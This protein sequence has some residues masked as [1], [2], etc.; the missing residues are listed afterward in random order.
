MS[1]GDILSIQDRE[2]GLG[3]SAEVRINIAR[4]PTHTEIDLPIYIFRGAKPGP[5]LLITASMHGDEI[6]GT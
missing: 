4:L 1:E 3:E 2:I 6:N 5:S